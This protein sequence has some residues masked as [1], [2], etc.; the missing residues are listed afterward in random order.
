V[1]ALGDAR[2][3]LGS[4]VRI[5]PGVVLDFRAGPI[6]L[7]DEVEIR[8]FTRLA[9]PAFVGRS[10]TLLGGSLT[11]V[12]IGPRCKVRGEIEATVML[13]YSNK[14]H[15]GFLGHAYVGSWV[16]LGAFTTNSDLK[17]NYGTV[18]IW[19]PAGEVDTGEMKIGCFLGDHVKT[20]IGSLI[21]T[22]TVVGP[23]SNL[24]GGMPPKYVPAFS[25]GAD[26]GEYEFEK[27]MATARIALSRRSVPL[28]DGYR[29]MLQRAW[30][31]G[32]R[33]GVSVSP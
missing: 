7:D 31:R 24:F 32:R 9:G 33:L 16:N 28:S 26:L 19:T 20:A 3:S 13:G 14:A 12:T 30:Q 27:F 17:N 23:G 29:E 1:I 2:L 8:A 22:G 15:D 5:E 21:N 18:R 10:S 4:N 6:R 11:A 25:W